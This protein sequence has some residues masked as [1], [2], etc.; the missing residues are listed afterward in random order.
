MLDRRLYSIVVNA[1]DAESVVKYP[2]DFDIR[3]IVQKSLYL[4]T[5]GKDENKITIPYNW[6]FYLRGPYSSE[7]AHMLYYME[8]FLDELSSTPQPLSEE[9]Q[10]IINQFNMFK[11]T[12]ESQFRERGLN[13]F[14]GRVF[15]ALATL[16]YISKQVGREN[17][18]ILL[19]F[20]RLK[21]NLFQE[22]SQPII[23]LLLQCLKNFNFL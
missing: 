9:D 19:I 11:A 23:E 8:D 10:T 12:L 1:L 17:E 15:E 22:L 3:L 7:I 6:S 20:Q 5:H 16:V 2:L 14:S 18:K 13:A 21:F 4:L